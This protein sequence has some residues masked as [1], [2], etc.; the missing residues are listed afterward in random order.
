MTKSVKQRHEVLLGI[1]L[2]ELGLVPFVEEFQFDA[3]RK[4]RC[5]FAIPLKKLAIEIEG[6]APRARGGMGRH[7]RPIGFQN[8]LAKYNTLTANGWTLFRFSVNDILT[9]AELPFLKEW[10]KTTR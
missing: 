3:L 5:D 4:W 2:Q 6:F 9:G 7:Q 8:D 10:L 1:H